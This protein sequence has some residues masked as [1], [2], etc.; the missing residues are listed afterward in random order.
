MN[1][2]ELKSAVLHKQH[3]ICLQHDR[4]Q[5][6]QRQKLPVF[7][8]HVWADVLWSEECCTDLARGVTQL[9]FH[10]LTIN[11]NHRCR[12]KTKSKQRP[13]SSF[14]YNG[15]EIL[16]PN[17]ISLIIPVLEK[18]F[19]RYMECKGMLKITSAM[20]NIWPDHQTQWG[21]ICIFS[22]PSGTTFRKII[23]T[24]LFRFSQSVT[25]EL[26]SSGTRVNQDD[27]LCSWHSNSSKRCLIEVWSWLCPVHSISSTLST[28]VNHGR[29]LHRGIVMLK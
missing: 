22:H 26:V 1:I 21:V 6:L 17:W 2:P 3:V 27:L 14:T 7:K 24:C 16:F 29:F 25:I 10:R 23:G 5:R 9:E 28:S 4:I 20:D 18:S 15:T 19:I 13:S 12:G 11:C 8:V